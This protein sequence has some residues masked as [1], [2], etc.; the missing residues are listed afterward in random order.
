V[1]LRSGSAC[2]RTIWAK[3]TATV[4]A[5]SQP[6]PPLTHDSIQPRLDL[7]T[8]TG[9]PLRLK[10]DGR[11]SAPF[12][13]DRCQH[14]CQAAGRRPTHVDTLE[15]RP[16][17]RPV[18]NGPGR[19][20][21]SYGSVTV[22]PYSSEVQQPTRATAILSSHPHTCPAAPSDREQDLAGSLH[23]EGQSSVDQT[24]TEREV[25]SRSSQLRTPP[26]YGLRSRESC[27]S[28]RRGPGRR[29]GPV[30]TRRTSR[31]TLI[32]LPV[33]NL[34]IRRDYCEVFREDGA[35]AARP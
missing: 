35:V 7:I 30:G 8:R 13:R 31:L 20:A 27:D 22:V 4:T 34:L 26:T 1:A 9:R 15:Y 28:G 19:L 24:W 21:H 29:P 16:S 3:L 11:G 23:P 6:T 17:P 5:T 12:R 14:G 25:C 2:H 10:A 18:T 32:S 33:G